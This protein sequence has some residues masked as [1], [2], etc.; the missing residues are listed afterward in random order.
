MT[1]GSAN[2][3]VPFWGPYAASKAA[4]E[5]L[6]QTYAAEMKKTP[7]KINLVDP[8][9][10]AT[11]LLKQALPGLDAEAVPAPQDQTDVFMYLASDSCQESGHIFKSA[12]F[13]APLEQV[14]QSA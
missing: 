5:K 3:S 11:D 13:I 8:G 12:D 2:E 9:T 4:L 1:A 10:M 14:L 7:L 6:V